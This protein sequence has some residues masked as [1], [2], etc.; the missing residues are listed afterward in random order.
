MLQLTG[1]MKAII[2]TA[3]LAEDGSAHVVGRTDDAILFGTCRVERQGVQAVWSRVLSHDGTN[4]ATI[5]TSWMI[6]HDDP[7]PVPASLK[8]ILPGEPPTFVAPG[9]LFEV[10]LQQNS[11]R[12]S[13]V[14]M[15][16]D[17][18]EALMR[19][20]LNSGS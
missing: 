9:D 11:E 3:G 10:E 13:T 16:Q 2:L 17:E 8:T 7:P 14:R 18:F 1:G 15:S 20:L 5:L 19:G 12:R 4:R 6:G